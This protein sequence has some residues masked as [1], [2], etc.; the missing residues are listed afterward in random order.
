MNIKFTSKKHSLC[1]HN[2]TVV[3]LQSRNVKEELLA[4]Y[5]DIVGE[6]K[7]GAG[8][9]VDA[10]KIQALLKVEKFALDL[11]LDLHLEQQVVKH[12][13]LYCSFKYCQYRMPLRVLLSVKDKLILKHPVAEVHELHCIFSYYKYGAPL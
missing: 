2:T 12:R 9:E 4:E 3:D 5:Q 11:T 1:A 13:E 6:C 7:E 10:E 8:V